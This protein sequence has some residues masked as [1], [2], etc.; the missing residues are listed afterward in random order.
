MTFGVPMKKQMITEHTKVVDGIGM[1]IQDIIEQIGLIVV[2]MSMQVVARSNHLHS[3]FL[4]SLQ[5][6]FKTLRNCISPPEDH[7]R[8]LEEDDIVVLPVVPELLQVAHHIEPFLAQSVVK[9]RDERVGVFI[10]EEDVFCCRNEYFHLK[11]VL[12]VSL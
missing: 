3:F 9:K 5:A 1:G 6:G 10:V 4:Q 11:I 8:P 2:D 12:N 7:F